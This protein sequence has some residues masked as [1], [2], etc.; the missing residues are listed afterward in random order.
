M[1][2]ILEAVV[3]MLALYGRLPAKPLIFALGVHIVIFALLF[4][5]FSLF[6]AYEFLI[7]L[8]KAAQH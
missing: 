2:N 7:F 4:I 6:G 3:R 1:R 5:V 8:H